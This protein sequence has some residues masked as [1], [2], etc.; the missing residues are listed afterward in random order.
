MILIF[1]KAKAEN[2]AIGENFDKK[3]ATN[4]YP[5][6]VDNERGSPSKDKGQPIKVSLEISYNYNVALR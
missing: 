4:E 5:I 1:L 3:F 2:H 6:F